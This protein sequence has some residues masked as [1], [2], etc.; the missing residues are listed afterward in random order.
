[1]NQQPTTIPR[2]GKTT[3]FTLMMSFLSAFIFL[4]SLPLMISAKKV[5]PNGVVTSSAAAALADTTVLS[6]T[7]QGTVAITVPV[8]LGVLDLALELEDNGGTLSGHVNDQWTLVYGNGEMPTLHGSVDT[9]AITP[10]FT[11]VSDPFNGQV[12]GR[13][14]QRSFTLVG[15]ALEG[16]EVLQGHYTEVITGF[17]PHPMTME[18]LFM[19]TRAPDV[20]H[21][22]QLVLSSDATLLP[23]GDAQ[24]TVSVTVLDLEGQPVSGTEV[25]FS[26]NLGEV[27]PA[28]ATTNA[29]GIATTAFTSGNTPGQ[30]TITA[31][32][33]NGAT[34]G[35]R[36]QIED[37]AP[38]SI[39]LQV[40]HNALE[41]NGET[42]I[43]AIVR[44]Q[45][46][47]PV[48]GVAVTLFGS[49][50]S[51]SPESATSD[52]NGQISA[53]FSAGSDYGQ[54]TITVL[55]ESAENSANIEITD[56]PTSTYS[57]SLVPGWN[58]V[59]I[60]VRPDSTQPADVFASIAGNY[61]AVYAYGNCTSWQ[62]YNPSSPPFANTLTSIDETK[63]FWIN[64][65]V[66]DTLE[67]AGTIPDSTTISL[68]EGW[69]LV[70]YPATQTQPIADALNSIAGAY[71]TA[72]AHDAT[73][74]SWQLYN[75]SAPP[76]ANTL[77]D[78][79]TGRGYW[80]N[81][82]QTGELTIGN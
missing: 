18:G 82:T 54:A 71:D 63:G 59:S 70:G 74:D 43:T 55:A 28:T 45:F 14:V 3:R 46:N 35:V 50:G 76:F 69:N 37:A 16:G 34:Q 22:T 24:A 47:Q 64:M 73:T 68:C 57:I 61:E 65:T 44:D 72:N 5:E 8:Q 23:V 48:S 25:S 33:C 41:P 52:E 7:Y 17:I 51:V 4:L 39:D 62:S 53:T 1:M 31:S 40:G 38:S 67:V 80:I 66:A 20:A 29:E 75:P 77:N 11:I 26:S 81:A 9:S 10:T 79:R 2:Y 42:S 78:M 6:G 58:L 36:L 60:P 27:S 49:L 30:A 12:S 56:N 13:Q 19:V 15:E 32:C 21:D